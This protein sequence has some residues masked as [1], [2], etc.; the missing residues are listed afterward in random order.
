MITLK[1]H[2]TRIYGKTLPYKNNV[3]FENLS[4]N[5]TQSYDISA[6]ITYY[7]IVTYESNN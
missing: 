2:I 1:I 4:N 6:E 5:L 7:K 3:L